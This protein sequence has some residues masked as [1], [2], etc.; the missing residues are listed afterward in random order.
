MFLEPTH[1]SS[2]VGRPDIWFEQMLQNRRK[3]MKLFSLSQHC[4]F[5]DVEILSIIE[6]HSLCTV[7]PGI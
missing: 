2:L 6:A 1:Q 7:I 3:N 5:G 4:N